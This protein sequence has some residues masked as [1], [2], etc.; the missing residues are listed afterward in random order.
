MSSLSSESQRSQFPRHAIRDGLSPK[1]CDRTAT[2]KRPSLDDPF[3][4][5]IPV[6]AAFEGVADAD[7]YR[8]LPDEWALATTDIVGSTNAIEEGGYKSVNMAGASMISALLNALGRRDLPFVFGG[9]GAMVAVP[10]SALDITR[11]TLAATQAWVKDE[12]DL[13]LR[14]AIVPMSTIRARGLDVRV[15]RFQA[16]DNVSYAMFTGGGASWAEARDEGRPTHSATGAAGTRPDLT[17]LSCRWNPIEARHGEIVSV[18]AVPAPGGTRTRLPDAG[19]RHRCNRRRAGPRRSSRSHRWTRTRL[20]VGQHRPGGA[21]ACAERQAVDGQGR[22]SGPD[23]LD[24][25][26]CRAQHKARLVRSG[27][28]PPRCGRQFGLS[29]VR[30]WAEDDHRPG[31]GWLRRHPSS[32]SNGRN[33]PES[34]ASDCIARTPR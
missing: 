23:R 8:P 26:P 5:A 22:H 16:S 15:A 3:F 29:K 13:T 12:L 28:V 7:N 9:D 11:E 14:A 20:F 4:A 33:W 21:R 6:F 32:A 34:A 31:P 18:I 2:W 27:A 1:K 24:Q 25:D 10:G 17:G 30:R 19:L